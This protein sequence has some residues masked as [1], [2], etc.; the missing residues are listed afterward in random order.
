MQRLR[1]R[2]RSCDEHPDLFDGR[3]VCAGRVRRLHDARRR[4]PLLSDPGRR[5]A[6]CTLRT[7]L[8][9]PAGHGS[10]PV[11]G[12]AMARLAQMLRRLDRQRL[13]VHVTPVVRDMVEAMARRCRCRARGAAARLLGPALTDR[14]LDRMRRARE[15][16]LDP[17]LHNTVSPTILATTEKFNV[18]PERGRASSLDGRL[19]PG[20]RAR[21]PDRASSARVVGRGR[22]DRGPAPRPRPAEPDMALFETLAGDPARARSRLRPRSRC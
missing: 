19:L 11:R 7:T 10:M 12:G 14:V 6:G 16:L 17:I 9:G 8:R 18:I 20:L 22:R 1:R 21:G 5:E 3:A 4:P 15:R 13:P 2:V